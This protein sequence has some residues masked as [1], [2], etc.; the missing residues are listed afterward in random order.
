M[1]VTEPVI[2]QESDQD[3]AAAAA[4]RGESLFVTG[5]AGT[6]K[7]TLLRF[8][9]SKIPNMIVV[10]PTGVAAINVG[11]QTIHSVFR[12]NPHILEYDEQSPLPYKQASLLKYAGCIAVDEVSM[13]RPDL[14]TLVDRRLREATKK[15]KPF[16]G[17]QMLF[18]GD[19]WQLPPVLE[20]NTLSGYLVKKFGGC[21]FFHCSSLR[22]HGVKL[23]ELRHIYRQT[24]Q[25]F[26]T[27]LNSIREDTDLYKTLPELNTRVNDSI[28][29]EESKAMFLTTT[30]KDAEQTNNQRLH[31]LPGTARKFTCTIT[32]TFND[33]HLPADKVLH[34]KAGARVMMLK[35][36]EEYVN[37]SLGTVTDFDATGL[38]YVDL[39]N[40]QYIKVAQDK[41]QNVRY[42]LDEGHDVPK[43][44]TEIIGE[45]IQLPVRLGF[46]VTIHKA[47]GHTFDRVHIDL[48]RGAFA[49]GQTY[50]A[51]SRCR[52]LD[53]ITL[54][55]PIDA[56]DVWTDSTLRGF[57]EFFPQTI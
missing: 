16:G 38:P 20:S 6:G 8:L 34:L 7:S 11:G 32:G 48:G 25:G 13:V 30:N 53:G 28:K 26:I 37:G 52:T 43:I 49:N 29:H 55:R 47:Q 39:D 40:G 21:H 36:G 5:K 45:F 3:R 42:T 46:A 14:M 50:V 24:D 31:N 56:S 51:L 44:R 22:E 19:P 1:P 4:I 27:L 10:A 23:A 15:D 54:E 33:S 9:Q 57:R 2:V 18:F 17:K 12:L 35:N 41:W